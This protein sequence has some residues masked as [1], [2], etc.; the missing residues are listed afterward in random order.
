[1]NPRRKPCQATKITFLFFNDFYV[2]YH[3]IVSCIVDY[4]LTFHLCPKTSLYIPLDKSSGQAPLLKSNEL[5]GSMEEAG[6]YFLGQVSGWSEPRLD[7]P[8]HRQRLDRAKDRIRMHTAEF[9]TPEDLGDRALNHE[10]G[11]LHLAEAFTRP[12]K[13]ISPPDPL[14]LQW[15]NL[16]HRA[17][18]VQLPQT[19]C[20]SV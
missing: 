20:G 16:L 4:P 2:F 18:V 12:H 9:V 17:F 5:V 13:S 3:F 15:N 19:I 8:S 6:C 1:L 11:E 10:S 14:T 7:T